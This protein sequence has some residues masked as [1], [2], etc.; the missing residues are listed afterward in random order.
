MTPKGWSKKSLANIALITPPKPKGI[1]DSN[2]VNFIA[3]SDVSEMSQIIRTETKPYSVVKNGFTSFQN[4]DVLIAKITPCFENGKGALVNNLPNKYGFG[5][6]EFHVIRPNKDKLSEKFLFQLTVSPFFR[7]KGEANMVGSAGQKRVPKN[8][9]TT[10]KFLI[11]PLKEQHIIAN[12]L[13]AWD[14]AINQT[15]KL[16]KAKE[17]QKKAL[18]Q[19]LLTGKRR[20]KE[21]IKSE[22]YS[23]SKFF[24]Y[25]DG[26]LYCNVGS[27]AT[28]RNERNNTGKDI[29]VLSCTKYD[30]LVDSLEYFGKRVFS[31]DTSNYKIV[32]R[33]QFAYAT[34]HIEEGSIGLL[35]FYEKGLVSPMYTVFKTDDRVYV[36]FLYKVFK[37]ELYRHIFA[38]N[39]NASVNRRGSLR[40]KGFAKIKVALPSFDEQKKISGC[41]DVF[42]KEIRLL[43]NQ[44][45][46]FQKQKK[47]LMQKLLTGKIRVKV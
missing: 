36:P 19:Q 20:F 23:K 9:L 29:P 40:W 34:N 17:K 45:D 18:I 41:L 13:T 3:M 11:P 12:I 6:T 24:E 46:L 21:F 43:K 16:I 31:D 38:V 27:V 32:H 2:A 25:P 14:K 28:Q 22:K 33:G 4:G 15:D 8:Y 26:W 5:S 30:G 37:T 47:G 44:V 10:F 42:D 1:K 7:R 39:T 35:E